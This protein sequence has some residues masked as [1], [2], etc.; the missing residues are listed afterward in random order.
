MVDAPFA[1][2]SANTPLNDD[3]LESVFCRSFLSTAESMIFHKKGQGRKLVESAVDNLFSII[4][5]DFLLPISK[6][7]RE[8]LYSM[9]KRSR[10]KTRGECRSQSV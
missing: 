4:S 9:R 6:L 10:E 2:R 5:K 8:M 7:F 1:N 3:P